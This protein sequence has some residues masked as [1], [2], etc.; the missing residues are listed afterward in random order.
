MWKVIKEALVIRKNLRR[1]VYNSLPSA[2]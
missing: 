1:G 2:A